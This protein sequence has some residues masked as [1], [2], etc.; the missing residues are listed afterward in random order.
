MTGNRRANLMLNWY[1]REGKSLVGEEPLPGMSLD[2]ALQLF[3]TPFW[4]GMY[5]CWAVESE[6]IKTLQPH[7][8]HPINPAKYSYFVEAYKV[9][10]AE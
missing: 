10:E 5:H 1:E 3:D 2:D 6:H 4:N 7:A 9:N 8:K